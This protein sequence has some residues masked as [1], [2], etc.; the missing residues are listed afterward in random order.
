MHNIKEEW[1]P[2]ENV[3]QKL[4]FNNLHNFKRHIKS[5]KLTKGIRYVKRGVTLIN[6]NEFLDNFKQ[7]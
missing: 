7:D 6:Y 5:K 4:G 2:I 1:E 3:Y